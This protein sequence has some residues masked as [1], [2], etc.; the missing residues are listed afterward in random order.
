MTVSLIDSLLLGAGR[1]LV[2]PAVA[3][4]AGAVTPHHL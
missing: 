4:G 1:S 2:L 3:L